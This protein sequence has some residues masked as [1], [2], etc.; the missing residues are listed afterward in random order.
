M[1]DQQVQ[2]M[3][4]QIEA[5]TAQLRRELAN[6]DQLVARSTQ[7]IDRNL[8]TV[9]SAFDRA[10]AAAQSAGVLMRGAFAAVAGAGLIGGIIK[11]VDAYGQM[12][13]RM[14]AAA[15]SAAEYQVVQDHLLRTAQETYRPLAEAQELYIRT[16][17]VMRSLGFNTQQTLDITDSFSFQLVTNAATADKAA[18]ALDAYSKALQTGKIDADGWVSIQSAMPTIV[19]AIASGTGKSAEAIRKLG[20]EGK[21]ALDDLNTGL[22]ST[23]DANRKAAAEMSTS[24]QDALVNIG[25]AIS[26]FLG[27][28]EERTGAVAGLSQVLL[29][30]ADN[31][32]LVAVA[33]GGAGAAA[34]TLYVAKAGMAVKAALAQ[35][36]A[37]VDNARAAIRGAEAQRIYAQAQLQQAEASVAAAT[38]LQRLSL[39]QTQLLP[40]QAA[41][42]A[43]TE[44]LAIA[45]A[46]L[47]R[48]ATGGLLTALGGPMGLAILAGTAAAS[49][50]L[51]RDNADQASV[52]LDDLH[53]PVSQLREEFAKL[54]KDQREAS[55]VKWQQEQIA[56]A[57]KVKDAYGD[58]AQS[59]RSAAVTAPV[60][61]SGGQYNKQLADY[62]SIIDRLNEARASGEG[63]SPILQEVGNRLQLPP[64]TIQQW[65][66]QAGAVSDADQ[67][68]AMIAETLRVLTGVTD[69]NTVSTHENNAA[70]AGMSPAGQTYLETLQ[71]QLAGLQDNGDAIKIANRHIAENADLTETDRL[72]I[73]SAASAIES[74]KKKNKDATQG[75]K[76]RTKSLK[77]EIKALDAI[78]DRAL[79][80]RKRL[81]DL[82]EGIDGLRK[83]QA[84]GKITAAEMELGIKNLNAAYAAPAI[85]KR[86]EEERKLAEARRNSAE[87][88]RKA[89]EVVL[90]TRQDAINADV[91]GIGMGD[92]ERDQTER[93]N[94]VRQKYAEARRQLEE[95]QE[96]VSRR[97]S[98]DAYQQR[99]ADLEDFQARELQMEVDGYDARLVAQQD[100]RNGAKR[101]WANIRADAA[102][103]AG[104]TDEM[105]TTGFN[106]ARDALADF[107]V[108]GKANFK[109]F[110][111][112]V[113]A[114]MARIASQQ[115][116]SSL[117][118]TVVNWGVT[119][120]TNYYGGGGGNGM[121]PGSAGAVSS[122]LGA[123]QAGYSST[124]FRAQAKGGAWDGGVQMFAKGGAF[125]TNSV[126][127]RPTGFAMAGGGLGVAGEA[128][129]EAIMPLARGADGSLGVQ[130]VGGGGGSTIVQ[131]SVP[132]AVAL[133]DRSS[134]GMELDP[135]A[136]QQNMERQMQGVAER[137]IAS[138]WRPGGVS[139]RNTTGR[140]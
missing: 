18:S 109:D 45:Q 138:S 86:A 120:A 135:A 57:D 105:L 41:L 116:A 49:F 66:T 106:T 1:A 91:S 28:M 65:V 52:S 137:A 84:G 89:M 25:N 102:N 34:L 97:L 42:T 103:V 134:E 16:A 136:F 20:V 70:K 29:A 74:L 46:N 101:A 96:D 13:D 110:A 61:D 31:V 71:K 118:S 33:M 63:L 9:D 104:A 51:L 60:R 68:S 121:T 54:N 3:L 15:G 95:Q 35:R 17:D 14:K 75:S 79:P 23:V 37:E 10:G 127:T 12:S 111:T 77:D 39:V 80:E 50:L 125:A 30:L 119:A 82:K 107:A 27:G 132:V 131:V 38:G 122:N 113:I 87:A 58:L 32:D 43:S 11:Q 7:A 94:S 93:L 47:T 53:K 112:S 72:A 100:Y 62:Q 124:Y 4:V 88:Y 76:D 8:A 22:L 26:T 123:S 114:D 73:L 36:I 83:A 24:V 56:S 64:G 21:L 128:G 19:Q 117:L 115:A 92:D 129:P 85:Q 2:G 140:R 126:L 81:E 78:I 99:L 48:A 5:T 98:Q 133:G 90:Q 44:A 40:K 55:L 6:A 130:M 59:I 69:Q 67:R 108:T 139:H